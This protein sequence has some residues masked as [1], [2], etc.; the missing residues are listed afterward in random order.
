VRRQLVKASDG[1]KGWAGSCETRS[2]ERH[3]A[4]ERA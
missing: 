4:S 1:F 2:S 3:T